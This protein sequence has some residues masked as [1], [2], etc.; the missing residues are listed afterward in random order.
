MTSSPLVKPPD[1]SQ[2]A[3]ITLHRYD[4]QTQKVIETVKFAGAI[5]GSATS[6]HNS[7]RGHPGAEFAPK[8]VKCSACRWLEVTIYRRRVEMTYAVIVEPDPNAPATY[9]YDYVIHTVGMSDVPGEVDFI[10]IHQTASAF[11][12]V[13]LLT[14]RRTNPRTGVTT[15]FVPPQH[16]RALAQAATLDD[17]LREAYVNRAVA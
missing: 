1:L 2:Y 11:E 5:L 16:A 12:V 9:T 13:E 7:H 8:H 6:E 15:A 4:E 10:R 17:D 14:V 3:E